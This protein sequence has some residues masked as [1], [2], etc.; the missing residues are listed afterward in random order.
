MVCVV[1]LMLVFTSGLWVSV[2][3]YVVYSEVLKFLVEWYMGLFLF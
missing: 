3:Y 1:P 2:W